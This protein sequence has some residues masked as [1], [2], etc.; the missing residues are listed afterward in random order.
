MQYL[1]ILHSWLFQAHAI[2]KKEKKLNSAAS[3]SH[4]IAFFFILIILPL[5]EKKETPLVMQNNVPWKER[6]IK[7]KLNKIVICWYISHK[8]TGDRSALWSD[9]YHNNTHI[10]QAFSWLMAAVDTCN[11]AVH[12]QSRFFYLDSCHNTQNAVSQSHLLKYLQ[13]LMFTRMCGRMDIIKLK[14]KFS[15][16][17]FKSCGVLPQFPHW[18]VLP[19]WLHYWC[20]Y[21]MWL[22][23]SEIGCSNSVSTE[24]HRCSHIGRDQ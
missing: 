21:R 3:H 23:W 7:I 17:S 1:F 12:N 22:L 5:T 6:Y 11:V 20:Q 24:C 10:E 4:Y 2:K 14:K 16:K 15:A 13:P 18:S 9:R 8:Y 19:H